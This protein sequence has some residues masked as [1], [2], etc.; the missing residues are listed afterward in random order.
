MRARPIGDRLRRNVGRWG[1][2][3]VRRLLVH[4]VRNFRRAWRVGFPWMLEHVVITCNPDTTSSSL[5]SG[6]DLKVRPYGS[7]A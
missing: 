3:D 6:A 5:H 7:Q 4:D 2:T 1:R